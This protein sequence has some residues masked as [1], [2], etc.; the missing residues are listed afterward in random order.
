MFIIRGFG[1]DPPAAGRAF[2]VRSGHVC[3]GPGPHKPGLSH[4]GGHAEDHQSG[5]FPAEGSGKNIRL[6][7]S[8]AL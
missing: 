3:A 5:L 7:L 6:A 1:I 8:I 4:T 2:Q